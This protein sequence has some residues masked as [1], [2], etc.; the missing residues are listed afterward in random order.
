MRLIARE[1][2]VCVG[3]TAEEIGRE[4]G[5]LPRGWEAREIRFRCAAKQMMAGFLDAVEGQ[6]VG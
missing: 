3:V 5:R 2:I 6:V 4:K 1:K